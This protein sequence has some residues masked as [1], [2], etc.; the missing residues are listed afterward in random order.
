MPGRSE[1]FRTGSSV[2]NIKFPS[3]TVVPTLQS[4]RVRLGMRSE[5]SKCISNFSICP[6]I[7]SAWK[8]W[9]SEPHYQMFHEVADE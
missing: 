8:I 1:C 6:E 2:C 9:T 5:T 3:S 4:F 7:A